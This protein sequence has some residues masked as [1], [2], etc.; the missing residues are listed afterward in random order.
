MSEFVVKQNG[1][2]KS[3]GTYPETFYDKNT[4]KS[5]LAAGYKISVNGKPYKEE[6]K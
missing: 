6:R 4:V 5:M 3:R 2:I 1:T